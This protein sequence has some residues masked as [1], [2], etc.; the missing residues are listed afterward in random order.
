MIVLIAEGIAIDESESGFDRHIHRSVGRNH[1][2]ICRLRKD[3]ISDESGEIPCPIF[4]LI[5]TIMVNA[6]EW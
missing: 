2:P 4:C 3:T 1:Q 5:D 6:V